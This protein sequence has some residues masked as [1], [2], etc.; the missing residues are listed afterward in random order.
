MTHRIGGY[1]VLHLLFWECAT[2]FRSARWLGRALQTQE[3]RVDRLANDS[4]DSRGVTVCS[5][6]AM[7]ELVA[8]LVLATT[9]GPPLVDAATQ[10]FPG[11]L[12][13]AWKDPLGADPAGTPAS[14]V[15]VLLLAGL[16]AQLLCAAMNACIC[17]A[18]LCWA[19]TRIRS[20]Q[21]NKSD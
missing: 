6:A 13:S 19:C 7:L 2:P 16:G 18:D 1:Y 3:A 14:I 10:D 9:L 15:F 11:V 21:T 12:S 5:R 4:A 8:Y 20:K 17:V